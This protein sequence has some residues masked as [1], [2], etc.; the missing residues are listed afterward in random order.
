MI[1]KCFHSH[2]K[3]VPARNASEFFTGGP[4]DVTKCWIEGG[5]PFGDYNCDAPRALIESAI[6][7][8]QEETTRLA[9]PSNTFVIWTGL[10]FIDL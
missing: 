2:L 3:T 1:N 9:L 10:G 5:G 4:Y 7:F 6:K 8:V